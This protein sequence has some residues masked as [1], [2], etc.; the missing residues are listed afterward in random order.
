MLY[1]LARSKNYCY[2]RILAPSQH[3][4]GQ[5][6][7]HNYAFYL[8]VWCVFNL[9]AIAFQYGQNRTSFNSYRGIYQCFNH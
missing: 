8:D 9:Y 1:N 5:K 4:K 6:L 2:F 3:F 7:D